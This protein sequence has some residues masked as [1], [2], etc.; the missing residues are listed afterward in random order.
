MRHVFSVRIGPVGFRIGS[1]WREPIAALENLYRDYTKPEDGVADLNVRLFA[2]RPWRR[3]LRSSVEIGGDFM[4]AEALPL[5]LEQGLLAAE[6]AMNL[7]LA[8]GWR[9]HLLLHAACVERDG[10]ALLLTGESGSGKSTLSALLGARGWRFMGD[11]L[12]LLDLGSG[13]V[14]PFPRAISIKNAAIPVVEGAWQRQHS[15]PLLSGTPK[16]MIRHFVPPSDAIARMTEPATP[17]LILFPTFGGA[18]AVREMAVSEVFVRLTQA[19]TNYVALAEPGFDALTQLVR[20]VP[21]RA[22]DFP[23]AETAFSQIEAL[24]EELT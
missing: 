17:A 10:K 18:A 7:Q 14:H 11:E 9:R 13:A 3:R 20:T 4:L 22:I 19:S 2:R 21:A 24:W 16:G 23:D 6:M 15:G 12:S 5:P 1:D 8:L